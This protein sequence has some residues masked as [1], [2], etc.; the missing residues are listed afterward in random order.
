MDD[1]D[2]ITGK[3]LPCRLLQLE[4]SAT[5]ATIMS[6]LDIDWDVNANINA[7]FTDIPEMCCRIGVALREKRSM[8]PVILS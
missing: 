7:I 2:K 3:S 4:Q 6:P 1:L 8:V 5:G